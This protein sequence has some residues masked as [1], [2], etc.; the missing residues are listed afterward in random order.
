M[1]DYITY[2][3]I[4]NTIKTQ[5]VSELRT[6]PIDNLKTVYKKAQTLYNLADDKGMDKNPKFLEEFKGYMQENIY[7]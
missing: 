2:E 3:Q 1:F 5:G 4:K 7:T 6:I